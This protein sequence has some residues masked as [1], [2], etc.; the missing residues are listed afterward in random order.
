MGESVVSRT[1]QSRTNNLYI[2]CPSR[3]ARAQRMSK[4]AGLPGCKSLDDPPPQR[5]FVCPVLGFRQS[6][7]VGPFVSVSSGHSPPSLD[8]GVET[9][10]QRPSSETH[11]RIAPRPRWTPAP[12][13]IPLF[14]T[15]V[16]LGDP[17]DPWIPRPSEA[18]HIPL[19]ELST[20]SAQF[21]IHGL[22]QRLHRANPCPRPR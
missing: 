17:Q 15:R 13:S 1:T 21:V 3:R 11:R 2:M 18:V 22:P 20:G 16:R 8:R 7:F 14:V 9:A 4:V 6:R 19:R 10:P 5:G 12:P